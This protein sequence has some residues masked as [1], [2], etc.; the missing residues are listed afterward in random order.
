M[1]HQDRPSSSRP[2]RPW[3]RSLGEIAAALVVITVGK[4]AIAEPYYV[5]S[6]SME[7]TLLIGDGLLATKYPYGYSSASLPA[8]LVLPRTER[9]FGAVP[10]RG[11][12]VVFRWSGDRSQVW[13]KRVVGLPGERIEMRAGQLWI[14]GRPVRLQPDGESAIENGDGSTISAQ[15]YVETLP[16]GREHPILKLAGRQP[17]DD[18]PAVTVP[19][20]HLFVMGDNRDD[21]A[22]SRVAVDQGGAGALPVADVIGRVDAVVGSWNP[23]VTR[24]PAWE[25]PAGLRLSR[26]F[27]A[28]R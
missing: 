12:I 3:L 28:V 24:G 19:P 17:L 21:S 7:P 18:M 2:L 5:P 15:R 26:F 10:E 11:D 27:S 25:W 13:V 6:G 20:G 23:A 9:L 16:N 14:D 4:A 22:D 8:S 1:P